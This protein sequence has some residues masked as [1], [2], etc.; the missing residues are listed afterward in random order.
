MLIIKKEKKKDNITHQ[1]CILV[2]QS[3]GTEYFYKDISKPLIRLVETFSGSLRAKRRAALGCL[4]PAT[5]LVLRTSVRQWRGMNSVKGL[6]HCLSEG[7]S[8]KCSFSVENWNLSITV[9]LVEEQS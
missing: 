4:A 9:H 6:L 1:N 5:F 8:K 2:N 3:W 7:L